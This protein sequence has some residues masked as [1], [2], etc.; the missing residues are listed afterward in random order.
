MEL[1]NTVIS[2]LM[3]IVASFMD[4]KRRE[5]DDW[6]WLLLSSLTLP[7]TAYLYLLLWDTQYPV[8]ATASIALSSTLALVFYKFELYGGADAKAIISLALALPASFHGNRLHPFSPVTVFLNGLLISL[9][10]PASLLAY[11]LV[12]RPVLHKESL[13]AGLEGLP[14]HLRIGALFLGT[15][16]DWPKNFWAKILVKNGERLSFSPPLESY[17]P[18][19]SGGA[20]DRTWATPGI[21]LI[22]FIAVGHVLNVLYGDLLFPIFKLLSR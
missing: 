8:I 22:L 13:F 11:N 9:S 1:V 18:T 14:L 17:F 15:R 19:S 12:V 5:V 6:V 2:S 4:L 16:V 10:V 20:S 7:S 3:L 21:P